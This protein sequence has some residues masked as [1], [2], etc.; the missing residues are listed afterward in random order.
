MRLT[1]EEKRQRKVERVVERFKALMINTCINQTARL[2][3][4]LVRKRAVEPDGKLTCVSCGKRGFP[5]KPFDAG[6]WIGRTSKAVI[7]DPR[8]CH[9]Q[10]AA[11]NQY[12]A[13]PVNAGYDDYMRRRYGQQVMDELKRLSQTTKQWTREELA[14]LYVSYREELRRYD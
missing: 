14:E 6:H 13:G 2:F 4:E 9:P 8:N 1:D 10:C 7:F 12:E 11:C 3:Q 5:G